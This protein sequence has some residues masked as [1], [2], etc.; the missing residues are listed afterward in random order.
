[1]AA[2][3]RETP[4][5]PSVPTNGPCDHLAKRQY[6]RLLPAILI[7]DFDICSNIQ[8][9]HFQSICML[10]KFYEPSEPSE[11]HLCLARGSARLVSFYERAKGLARSARSA[12]SQ[13]K[14]GSLG[15]APTR[16]AANQRF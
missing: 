15:S 12:R 16:S 9:Q 10:Q 2:A 1:M 14:S 5:T 7:Q 11:P 3:L 8:K 4:Q 13:F 6:M